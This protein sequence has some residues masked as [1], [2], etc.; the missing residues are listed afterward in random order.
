MLLLQLLRRTTTTSRASS[1]I[2]I[3]I[4]QI[5]RTRIQ[6]AAT[7][8][9]PDVSTDVDL[10][11]SDTFLMMLIILCKISI[12]RFSGHVKLVSSR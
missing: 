7:V 12:I 11:V 3:I 9:R 5:K 2:I 6:V 8:N 4:I 1:I 10:D